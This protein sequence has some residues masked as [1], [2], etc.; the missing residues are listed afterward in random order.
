MY[1]ILEREQIRRLKEVGE[2]RPWSSDPVFQ[3]TYFCN[4]RREDDR[5]TRFFRSFYK[6]WVRHPMYEYNVILSRFLNHPPTIEDLDYIDKHD[7][8]YILNVL[9]SRARA[10]L[11]VWSGAYLITTHGLPMAKAQYLVN[12]VLQGASQLAGRNIYTGPVQ[13]YRPTLAHVYGLLRGLEGLGSFLAAQVVA[14]LKNS[15]GHPLS[16]APDWWTF[17]APGPGSLRG[18][19]WFHF[20]EIG[21]VTPSN[22]HTLFYDI[23]DYVEEK[24]PG[25]KICNQDLQNCLCEFDK[26]MRVSTGTGR[27]KRKYNGTHIG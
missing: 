10:G 16:D 24:V 15:P 5:V 6:Q 20:G 14:D 11:Q 9:E 21:K 1:W 26:Y 18:A 19:S 17:V 8:D 27:S 12:R 7:P 3:T 13:G 25:I 4:V 23:R 2:P 22:F